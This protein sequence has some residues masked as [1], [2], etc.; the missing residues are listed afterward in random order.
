MLTRTIKSIFIAL[1][2][3]VSLALLSSCHAPSNQK[4]IGIIVPIEHKA[5]DEIVK[6]F[7]ESLRAQSPFPLKFKVA[8]AQGDMNMQRAIIEQMKNEHYDIIVPI[9]TDA[10]EMTMAAVHDQPIVSLAATLTEAD[11]NKS[12]T[13][14]VA[15]V[16][17]EIP[18]AQSLQFIHQVYPQL[19]SLVL[20]HSTADKVFPEVQAAI[21]AGKSYGIK[22][23][24]MMVPTLNDLYSAANNIP[25]DAQGIF[26]LKDNLIASGINTL[27][28]SAAKRHIP[29]I[30]SDQGSVQDGAAFALGVHESDIGVVGAKLAAAILSGQKACQLPIVEM[31]YFLTVFVN[32]TTLAKENQP[33]EPIQ[34]TAKTGKYNIETVGKGK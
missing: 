10:T 5:L 18:A 29:L 1:F 16:D 28:I 34:N 30:T 19:T 22:V 20:V 14:N 2:S 7:T 11:R 13:C 6:G 4:T 23:T 24:P 27:A 8:N 32:T 31:K 21:A 33:L 17:D 12:K 9:G 26:I 15:V 3:F 25:A